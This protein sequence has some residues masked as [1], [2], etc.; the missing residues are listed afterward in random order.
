[1]QQ[2]VCSPTSTKPNDRVFLNSR[3]TLL[4]FL[5]CAFPKLRT[6]LDSSI[7]FKGKQHQW[8]SRPSGVVD[9]WHPV[10]QD[11]FRLQASD[12]LYG[13]DPY[14]VHC[15]IMFCGFALGLM[16][17]ALH[18]HSTSV[19]HAIDQKVGLFV[20]NF[21]SQTWMLRTLV[22]FVMEIREEGR[23]GRRQYHWCKF[24]FNSAIAIIALLCKPIF[25]SCSHLISIRLKARDRLPLELEHGRLE[26]M[27][28]D[29]KIHCSAPFRMTHI[30]CSQDK[31][32]G[33]TKPSACCYHS[34]WRH[35]ECLAVLPIPWPL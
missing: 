15:S 7:R 4:T 1:M 2:Q 10:F 6:K 23:S 16:I 30:D 5:I 13:D 32:D 11:R 25:A 33:E 9:P 3:H 18:S 28:Q 19:S 17:D 29:L 27:F 8:D 14:N 22:A 24:K 35:L 12:W 21:H 20:D 34:H 26:F 31:W